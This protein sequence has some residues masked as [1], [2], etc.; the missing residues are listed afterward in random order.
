MG[1]RVSCEEKFSHSSFCP[2]GS[3]VRPD[4]DEEEAKTDIAGSSVPLVEPQNNVN[5]A[6][7]RAFLCGFLLNLYKH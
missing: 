3:H 1:S 5:S 7:F 6:F 4:S 2:D